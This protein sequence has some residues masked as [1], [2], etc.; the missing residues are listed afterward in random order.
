MMKFIPVFL[1]ASLTLAAAVPAASE[2][3]AAKSAN[4]QVYVKTNMGGFTIELYPD[5]APKTVENFLN[6]VDKG[7]YAGTIFH[8]VIK[9]FMIQGGGF[10]KDMSQKPT[11]PAIKNEAGNGLKN[12][13]YT[14]AM[15]RT[16]VVD[17][18]TSQFFIN[19]VDNSGLDHKDNTQRGFGYCVFGK[20]IDGTDVIDKIEL[21]K[22]TTKGPYRDVPVK[23][24]II[25]AMTVISGDE[26]EE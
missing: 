18:A 13:K 17:S 15:A 5:K 4:P 2:E 1:A 25:K 10:T 8:R 19:T 16:N 24:V 20:V 26:E 22:T 11:G 3:G 21:V 7:Y 12:R 9:G 6:Y 23:P 14:I